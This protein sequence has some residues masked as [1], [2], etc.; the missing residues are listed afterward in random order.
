MWDLTHEGH[1]PLLRDLGPLML[2][3]LPLKTAVEVELA[4]MTGVKPPGL[5]RGEGPKALL[6]T[7][8]QRE[9]Y[10]SAEVGIYFLINNQLKIYVASLISKTKAF[11]SFMCAR[12]P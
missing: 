2:S 4:P 3:E 9:M 1:D 7:Q 6:D 5:S 10:F 12:D 11:C 8:R